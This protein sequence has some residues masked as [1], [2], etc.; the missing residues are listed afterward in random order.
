MKNLARKV[1]VLLKFDA[2][3]FC[4]IGE[5]AKIWLNKFAPKTKAL[6]SAH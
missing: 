1:R 2:L 4:E 3:K 5:S 6:K